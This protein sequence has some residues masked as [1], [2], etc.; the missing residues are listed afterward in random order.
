MSEVQLIL[1]NIKG[2]QIEYQN[3]V[4]LKNKV[5]ILSNLMRY[6]KNNIS[7]LDNFN[8]TDMFQF[9]YKVSADL[10]DKYQRYKDYDLHLSETILPIVYDL[11]E[12]IHWVDGE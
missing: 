10:L 9:F 7:V 11:Q 2:F 4:D 3:S 1:K 6:I 12:Y 5:L 8:N